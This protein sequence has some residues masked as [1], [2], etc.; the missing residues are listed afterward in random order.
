MTG[1]AKSHCAASW[2][3][4]V[5]LGPVEQEALDTMG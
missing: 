1:Q 2:L 4:V 3:V 5:Y